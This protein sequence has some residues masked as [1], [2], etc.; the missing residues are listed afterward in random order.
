LARLNSPLVGI[1][2]AAGSGSRF[3]G[4]KLLARLPDGMQVGAATLQ[5]L[6]TVIDRIVAVVRPGD[7]AL[8]RLLRAGGAEVVECER[9]GEGMG[10]S[11]S[12]G[13]SSATT[14]WPDAPGWLIVL[15]DMPWLLPANIERVAGALMRGAALA[16][17]MH[18]GQRGH[19][20]GISNRFRAD[21]VALSGDQGARELLFTHADEVEPVDATD[22]S[23]LR[24]VDTPQDLK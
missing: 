2:L 11:L 20:V 14:R 1:L 24:D 5:S 7:V 6:A 22:A 3:G 19:P 13:V 15:A 16:V 10:A 4:D 12:C 17:P 8:S 21:L 9:A 18:V 23:V